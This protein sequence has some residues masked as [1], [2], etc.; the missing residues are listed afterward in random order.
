[1][2]QTVGRFAPTPS[3]YT[4]FGNL[5]CYLLAWLSAKQQGGRIVLRM[6]D[7][8]TQRTSKAF[9]VAAMED[10]KW[11]GLYWDEGPKGNAPDSFYQSCRTQI[12]EACFEKLRQAGQIYPCYCSRNDVK[13]ANAPHTSDGRTVYPGTCRSL[14]PQQQAEQK[15][16]PAWRLKVPEKEI[17]FTDGVQGLYSQELSTGCG[18]FPVRRADDVFCYQLAVVLDDALMGI[19]EVVRARDLLSSTPQQIYLYSLLGMQIPRFY[20]IPTLLDANANRLAKRD[21][22]AG[23][24]KLRGQCTPQQV[25]GKLAFLAG[26]QPT[27]APRTLASLTEHFSWEN[28][29]RQ[30]ICVPDG[31]F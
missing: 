14:T 27:P 8:D 28:V 24:A 26:Q 9:A 22:S 21:G 30:D 4:H 11:L 20:H 6:E 12:Y 23:L 13:L 29:P 25:L 1:M 2:K 3:G 18:D 10:L 15:R 5:F 7:L 16:R 19:T 31:L 17:C